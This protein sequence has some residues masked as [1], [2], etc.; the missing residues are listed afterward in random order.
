MTFNDSNQEKMVLF[1][2]AWGVFDLLIGSEITSAYPGPAD[3][4]AFPFEKQ[5]L[6]SETIH[7]NISEKEQILNQLYMTVRDMRE[8]DVNRDK[9]SSILRQL[10]NEFQNDWLLSLEIC[11]LSKDKYEDIYELAYNYLMAFSD[12]NIDYKKLILD[13][14]KII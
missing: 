2:P 14:L 4:N 6:K 7:I 10:I 12:K 9:L 1:D 8:T 3:R 5:H 11:E 13:G